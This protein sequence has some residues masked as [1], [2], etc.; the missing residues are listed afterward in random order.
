MQLSITQHQVIVDVSAATSGSVH[1]FTLFKDQGLPRPVR[2]LL[3]L[4]GKVIVWA[5]SAY[6][7]LPKLA[8]RWDC[9][10]QEK[11]HR[12]HPL[13]ERQK[14]TNTCK[15]QTRILIEPGIRRIK[16]FRCCKEQGRKLNPVRQTQYWTIVAGLWNQRQA[17][18]LGLT[19][20]LN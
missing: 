4:M 8:P 11:A 12:N 14:L 20:I 13:T 6:E 15:T 10:I 1:D 19:A 16:I 9:R 7:A 18:T 3:A 2:R 17:A 5:D